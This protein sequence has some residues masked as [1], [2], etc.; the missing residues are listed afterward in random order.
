M[1]IELMPTADLL[2]TFYGDTTIDL[3]RAREG[4][5]TDVLREA[6]GGYG[7]DF[8][9]Y[10]LACAAELLRR[11]TAEQL[12]RE[13]LSAPSAV[14]DFLIAHFLGRE[15]ESFVVICLDAQNRVIDSAELFR[16]TLTQTSVYPREVVKHGLRF[17]AAAMIVAHCHPSGVAEPSRADEFLTSTLKAALAMVDIKLLDHF[18]VAG[19]AVLSFAERG[20]L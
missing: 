15:Y 3:L 7:A 10:A 5:V 12:T 20:L 1:E 11:A 9:S 16:G 17:N 13:S 6:R 8:G 19:G 4:S 18:I 14:R 2:A